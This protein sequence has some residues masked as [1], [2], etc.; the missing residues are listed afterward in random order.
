VTLRSSSWR[1]TAAARELGPL[2]GEAEYFDLI[3]RFG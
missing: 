2:G 1:L 3:Y